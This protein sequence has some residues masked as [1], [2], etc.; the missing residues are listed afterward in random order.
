MIAPGASDLRYPKPAA[1]NYPES[2]QFLYSLGNE[3]KTMKFGLERITALMAGLGNPQRMC[4]YV[5]VAG[6]NGKGSTSALIESALRAAGYKTGLYTSPH[7]KE[8]TERIQVNGQPVSEEDFLRGFHLVHETAERMVASG[9]MDMHPTYF[10]TMTAMA[11]VLFAEHGCE[12]VVLEVGMG[13][14]LDATNIVTP[15]LCVITQIAFD[16][17]KFLGETL[18]QIAGEKAGILKTGVPVVVSPQQ[19]EA[20]RV[21]ES[22]ASAVG[23][24]VFLAA[25]WP[26]TELEVTPEG[27]RFKT[28]PYEVEVNMAG[29]HQVENARTALAALHSLGLSE[30]DVQR[31]IA[32]ARWPGRL[33]L[34]RKQ[35]DI[36]LD[37]AHNP[38][39]AAAL[40]R[41]IERFF[42]GRRTW[43]IFGTMRDKDVDE[44]CRILFPLAYRVI[45]TAP[46]QA[47]SLEPEEIVRRSPVPQTEASPSIQQALD[48]VQ[49]EAAPEDVVFVT[50]SLYLVGEARTLLVQ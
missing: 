36:Y 34:V 50:G 21:V 29:E 39:G 1:M 26:V 4:R 25:G 16:H 6:T 27:S 38:A 46:K 33:E 5:H 42:S 31:G 45:A 15:E 12:W 48:R 11:F 17:Q 14:R 13:G 18:A 9:R 7:L 20:Q 10:E 3:Q 22:R 19:P 8:P 32:A 2:V 47:R 35:P 43:L 37:G 24:P 40:K 41:Y 44:V 30:T 49:A 28:G 23:A